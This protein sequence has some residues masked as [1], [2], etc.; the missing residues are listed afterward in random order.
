MC[1]FTVTVLTPNPAR[2]EAT[3]AA[4]PTIYFFEKT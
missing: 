3:M 4:D 2:V 1:K